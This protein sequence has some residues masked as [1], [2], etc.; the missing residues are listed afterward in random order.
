MEHDDYDSEEEDNDGY[1]LVRGI[2]ITDISMTVQQGHSILS[3]LLS[4]RLSETEGFPELFYDTKR[5]QLLVEDGNHRIMQKWL[6]G[7]DTFDGYVK[8]GD[9]HPWLAPVYEDEE[10]FDWDEDYRGE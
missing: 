7:E 3:N 10:M 4:G 1:E 8:E 6:D 9:W 2:P 5:D